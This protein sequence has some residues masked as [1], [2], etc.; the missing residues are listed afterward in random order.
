VEFNEAF[1]PFRAFRH[2]WAALKIAPFPL[3]LGALGMWFTAGNGGAGNF[4]DVGRALI[5]LQNG[6]DGG[7]DA[8]SYDNFDDWGE[9]LQALPT[10]LTDLVGRVQDVPP[11]LQELLDELGS[12]GIEAGMIAGI[13]GMVLLVSLFCGGIMMLIRSF[14]H[15]GYLRLHEQLVRDA[16]G[17]F[18]PLFSGADYLG[19]M[20]LWKLLKTAIVFGSTMVAGSPGFALVMI[21]A[22]QQNFGLAGVGVLLLLVLFFPALIYVQLGLALGAHAL[23]LERLSPMQALERSWSIAS[24]HRWELFIFL[25]AQAIVSFAAILVGLM[26]CCVGMIVTVPITMASIDVGMTEAFL[27]YTVDQ[28][29]RDSFKLPTLAE[30]MV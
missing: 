24:G 18:G 8:P 12:G 15:T 10:S 27:L 4:D 28:A 11:E 2:G 6:D 19:P 22:F 30:E 25:A 26:A 7:G 17:D 16:A 21:G 5:E 23:V 29:T 9:R 3:F 1:D 20:V 13:V 14:V